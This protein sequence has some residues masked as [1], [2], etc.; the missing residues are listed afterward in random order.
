VPETGDF[1]S[2]GELWG[3]WK[4]WDSIPDGSDRKSGTG[5]EIEKSLR[6]KYW[7]IREGR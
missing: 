4:R 6:M 5:R 2:G 7:I 3:G 1:L